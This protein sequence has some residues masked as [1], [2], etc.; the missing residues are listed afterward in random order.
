MKRVGQEL[1]ASCY[2]DVRSGRRTIAQ[3]VAAHPE[4]G[5]ELGDLLELASSIASTPPVSPDPVFRA[6]GRAALLQAIEADRRGSGIASALR[7][8]FGPFGGSQA[9]PLPAAGLRRALAH[10]ALAF[11]LLV[12]LVGGGAAYA[13]QGSLPG[14]PL[15]DV[16]LLSEGARLQLALSDL[17]KARLYLDLSE[18]RLAEL[19]R[20]AAENRLGQAPGLVSTYEAQLAWVEQH[21]DGVAF[22]DEETRQRELARLRERSQAQ[23]AR[24]AKLQ[25]VAPADLAPGL[26]VAADRARGLPA[27]AEAGWQVAPGLRK[28]SPPAQPGGA[29]TEEAVPA[30]LTQLDQAVGSLAGD[31]PQPGNSYTSLLAKVQSAED[32]FS[33]GQPATAL[34]VLA[35][36]ESELEAYRR[37]GR[38]PDAAYEQLQTLRNQAAAAL[39]AQTTPAGNGAE[40]GSK[41]SPVP[42]ENQGK[43]S[44]PAPG[45]DRGKNPPEEK[46]ESRKP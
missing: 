37:E 35:A 20:L 40:K 23:A 18:A 15:Y 30:A 10:V 44:S 13:A 9:D 24:L 17:D 31:A 11:A 22:G 43:D 38:V 34:N 4:V 25:N 36:F 12:A 39:K 42:G 6:S 16:K 7:R 32:A 26:A 5:N 1:F 14:E 8:L 19:E 21:V 29:R 46:N 2:E 33:R 27:R 3:C 28:D 41:A 45:L